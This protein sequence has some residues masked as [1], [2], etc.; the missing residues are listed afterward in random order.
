MPQEALQRVADRVAAKLP[1]LPQ[2]NVLASPAEAP[3]PLRDFIE[4][5]G[6]TRDVE[7][8]LYEGEI[9]LFASGLT[10]ETRAEFVLAEHEAAHAGLRGLL[11]PGLTQAMQAIANQ[12]AS[13]RASA[14]RL[15]AANEGMTLAEAVEEVLVDI[16]TADLAKLRGWRSLVARLRDALAKLG[17]ERMAGAIDT[18]LAGSLTEQQRADL[19][20]AELVRA[21]RGYVQQRRASATGGTLAPV[22]SDG[23]RRPPPANPDPDEPS[24]VRAWRGLKQRAQALT[25]PEN[26]AKLVYELQDKFIDLRNLR[27]HIEK[28]G[29]TITDLN[30]AYLGEELYHKRLAKR[31]DDF[32]KTELRPLL[33]DMRNRGI[34][35]GTLE[36]FL[37]ARHAREANRVLA[38]RNPTQEMID[39][40]KEKAD[41]EVRALEVQLQGAKARGGATRAIE[42][43]L[44]M[45]RDARA[46]WNGVQAFKGTEEERLSLSGMSDAEAEAF[47]EGLPAGQRSHLDELAGRVDAINAKTVDT[48]ERYGLMDKAT[49]DAWRATYQ[50]YV[51]L[52]RDEAHPDSVSHPIGQGFST[53]GD[54]AK[55]RVGSNAKVTNILAHVAM[56]RESALTRGEKNLVAKRLYLMAAQNPA[57]EW[58]AVDKPPT[59]KTVDTSTGFVRSGVDPLYK[60]RPN[61]VMVRI[62]GKDAAVVFNERNPAAARLAQSIKSQDLDDLGAVTMAAGRFTRLI[63]AMSTQYNPVFSVVNF[64]RDVQGGI[65]NLTNTPMA[66][67]KAQVFRDIFPALRAIYGEVRASRRGKA[68]PVGPWVDLWQR[69]QQEGGTTG[70]RDLYIDASDRVKALQGEIEKADRGRIMTALDHFVIGWVSDLNEAVE[71]SVRLA[72]Y[73]AATDSG[74]SA[75]RAASQAKNITV[76]FNRKGRQSAKLGAWYAFFNAAIQGNTRMVETLRGPMGRRII[77]GGIGLGAL[78]TLFAVAALGGDGDDDEYKN[79]PEFVKSRNLIIPLGGKEY[80]TIPLPLGFH[81]LPNIG[82]LLTEYAL[83]RRED[84]TTGETVGEM[85][86]MVLDAFNPLGGSE[87]LAM[88]AAPTPL[89]IP[90]G[91]MM[92]RDWQNRPIARENRSDQDPQPAHKLTRDTAS[93]PSKAVSQALN[94]VGGGNDYT[95]GAKILQWTPDQIDYVI[96]QLAGGLGRE[97]VKSLQVANSAATGD[98]LPP[99]KIPLI[100]RF[101]GSTEGPSGQATQYHENVRRLNLIDNEIRG[102]A[103]DEAEGTLEPGEKTASEF[104]ETQPLAVMLTAASR[105]ERQIQALRQQRARLVRQAEP[106]Y[107]DEVKRINEQIGEVMGELNREVARV[108]REAKEAKA[109]AAQ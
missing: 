25:S 105:A 10:D 98:E 19:M 57:P 95:P 45:A 69:M 71:N 50:H 79:L 32:L 82:R 72:V 66:D 3:P 67:R 104:A 59:I 103:R 46:A 74:L 12:N 21:A 2:V 55:R 62:A 64:V 22:L 29:G 108:R 81:V 7:G 56:Q 49:L 42:E 63:A 41:A 39:A 70:Y 37:H 86:A 89:D 52:H 73:K 8:A 20:A 68:G 94:W 97:V 33:G 14:T 84:A 83:G 31:T 13:V 36:Q 76:N 34:D 27:E 23:T 5:R 77:A 16:P 38:E 17:F 6:A 80:V 58:W 4:R 48:L 47:I 107:Q 75:P 101:Y 61:V 100:G 92:N 106:G 30:D 87:N 28:L 40:G 15:Q 11:G 78:N 88:V 93:A 51:P 102:R 35:R 44:Q 54:A 109:A 26:V 24:T 99:Y 65:L 85:L 90:V 60:N 91:L 96:G 18:F 1:G 9:Y 43:A 53:K